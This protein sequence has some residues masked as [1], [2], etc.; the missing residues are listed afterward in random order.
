ML[1]KVEFTFVGIFIRV[2]S[3]RV[4]TSFSLLLFFSLREIAP[5]SFDGATSG[6]HTL[7]YF[8]FTWW[9]FSA[10]FEVSQNFEIFVFILWGNC[11]LLTTKVQTFFF[12]A[13]WAFEFEMLFKEGYVTSNP[14]FL[15]RTDSFPSLFFN[16]SKKL[17]SILLTQ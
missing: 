2:L 17:H 9:R 3:D 14:T 11:I 12:T 4:S 16:T 7:Y 8:A 15:H 6:V 5:L 1:Q 10:I 13:W